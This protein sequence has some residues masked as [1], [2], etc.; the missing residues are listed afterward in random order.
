MAKNEYRFKVSGGAIVSPTST[1]KSAAWDAV[2]ENLTTLAKEDKKSD[3][4]KPGDTTPVKTFGDTGALS[5]W[6]HMQNQHGKEIYYAQCNFHL[7]KAKHG[8][9][10]TGTK[11]SA[12]L[13]QAKCS[14]P[15]HPGFKP[16][17]Y[18][19]FEEK[20]EWEALNPSEEWGDDVYMQLYSDMP[21]GANLTA[22]SRRALAELNAALTTEELCKA[23]GG[24]WS[25]GW[26]ADDLEWGTH[27]EKMGG[28]YLHGRASVS[29]GAFGQKYV[30]SDGE[31]T[32]KFT[33]EQSAWTFAKAVYAEV[34]KCKRLADLLFE[35]NL[36]PEGS[37]EFDKTDAFKDA[38]AQAIK[39]SDPP[40]VE[41]VIAPP[42]ETKSVGF[43]EQCFVL[44]KI[45]DLADWR[46]KEIDRKEQ[47]PLPYHGDTNFN[48]CI[49][50]QGDP[51]SFINR[52]AVYPSQEQ[53][54]NM[55]TAEISNVQPTI[56][57]FKVQ[58][59]DKNKEVITEI[60]FGT[61]VTKKDVEDLLQ[62]KGR[63][64]ATGVGIEKFDLKLVGTTVYSAQ[65]DL[66][67]TLTIFA[68][69]LGDLLKERTHSNGQKWR[70]IDLALHT[71][72]TKTDLAQFKSMNAKEAHQTIEN[73]KDLSFK[74][75]AVIGTAEP[76]GTV[77]NNE[78]LKGAL[79]QNRI[80][81]EM[82]PTDYEL[83]F[84]DDG[85]LRFVV[86]FKPWVNQQ[87]G[88]VTYDIFN[89]A[90]NNEF[91]LASKLKEMILSADCDP[92]G[93]KEFKKIQLTQAT[94]MRKGSIQSIV[95]S[96]QRFGKM[97]YIYLP[98]SLLEELKKNP[99]ITM[100]AID[101]VREI[102]IGSPTPAQQLRKQ[103]AQLQGATVRTSS[104][105]ARV[106]QQAMSAKQSELVYF[107]LSDL[108]DVIMLGTDDRL[109]PEFF[110]ARLNKIQD[111]E[112]GAKGKLT[113]AII[114]EQQRLNK[115]EYNHYK[116]LRVVLGPIELI[117]P[118]DVTQAKIVNLGDIPISLKYF[119]EFMTAETL[120]K[121]LFSLSLDVFLNKLISKML[122]SFL[123]D[124]TCFSGM[125]K[126]KTK[127]QQSMFHATNRL[128]NSDAKGTPPKSD[129]LT[130]WIAI[131][132]GAW[133][134][135][136]GPPKD[137]K[138]NL[139]VSRLY[140]AVSP[141]NTRTPLLDVGSDVLRSNNA[142]YNSY[143]YLV[144]YTARALPVE[145]YTGDRTIDAARGVHHYA[146]ARDRGI[147]KTIKLNRTEMPHHRETRHAQEGYD[148]LRQIRQTYNIDV[149]TY[150]NF[151]VWMGQT[152]FLDPQGWVPYLDPDTSTKFGG[153]KG[154]SELGIGGYYSIV[155]TEHSFGPG[156]FETQFTAVWTAQTERLASEATTQ[157]PTQPKPQ[158]TPHP[159]GKCKTTA[160]EGSPGGDPQSQEDTKIPINA[161][162]AALAESMAPPG[163]KVGAKGEITLNPQGPTPQS[164]PGKPTPR[165]PNQS[166]MRDIPSTAPAPNPAA[167]SRP[168]HP[169]QAS[170]GV[171]TGFGG[172]TPPKP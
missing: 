20:K 80:T 23:A 170:V 158:E 77:G 25:D 14:N 48:S 16:Q 90:A 107:Y 1:D 3:W 171:P 73:L 162:K 57:F 127:L 126:Q 102:S 64:R 74:I 50:C 142:K 165:Q 130:E 32:S 119:M 168:E 105:D 134:E 75:K 34:I 45:V 118:F 87:F 52:L 63:K 146:T 70:Y 151:G 78:V 51:F 154:L 116:Q 54:L 99:S 66:E 89:N 61:S 91:R 135:A 33:G 148:G 152:I 112:I 159:A 31:L 49:M 136:Q 161:R 43:R 84:E 109:D 60:D 108:I 114:A 141:A 164:N 169:R 53:F 59:D 160:T 103:L 13:P 27:G 95:E 111:K 82:K 93:L 76:L 42:D 110:Q 147:I 29:A 125:V 22:L 86:H 88:R 117:D 24:T 36:P 69:D 166:K 39:D 30:F 132:R 145:P 97:R 47:K 124:D 113:D 15:T 67:A 98:T 96:L 92:E 9:T 167:R 144:F 163:A 149:T 143:N 128:P 122:S 137:T 56:R 139:C 115:K 123:N 153:I 35:R 62:S 58:Q 40:K 2:M 71:T 28:T 150:A 131:Q 17:R 8:L 133:F 83:N 65:L 55:P 138:G 140:P 104:G 18:A 10:G 37:Q 120:Q 6:D 106:G 81:L 26:S 94:A 5:M 46:V 155:N 11:D 72:A 38:I 12:G 21:S 121:N 44:S 79:K 41:T 4:Y 101:K 85:T 172:S 68:T 129:D 7:E 156:H 157:L 100:G 19:T